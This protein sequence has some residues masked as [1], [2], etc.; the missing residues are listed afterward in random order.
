M[1]DKY[2]VFFA[3]VPACNII[4]I[5]PASERNELSCR[6]SFGKSSHCFSQG[7]PRQKVPGLKFY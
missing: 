5:L 7:L 2:F 6:I 4:I 3:D 1:N